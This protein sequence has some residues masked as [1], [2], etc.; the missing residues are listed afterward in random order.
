MPPET[1]KLPIRLPIISFTADSM[2]PTAGTQRERVI[3]EPDLRIRQL[4][5]REMLS[6]FGRHRFYSSK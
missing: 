5:E 4:F 2:S 3:R 6:E 1:R